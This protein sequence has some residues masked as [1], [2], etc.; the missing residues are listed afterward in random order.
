MAAH[1]RRLASEPGITARSVA[2]VDDGRTVFTRTMG[3]ADRKARRPVDDRTVFRPA[4]L[5][6]PVFAYLV[7]R[8]ADE[9]VLDLDTPVVRDLPKPLPAYPAY[10]SLRDDTRYVRRA[11]RGRSGQRPR[12]ADPGVAAYRERGGVAP[13]HGGRLRPVPRRRAD[14]R[15]P[16]CEEPRR[17]AG[18]GGGPAIVMLSVS[19]RPDSF[20]APLVEAAIGSAYSPLAW[21]ESGHIVPSEPS[22]RVLRWGLAGLAL[23]LP[24]LVLWR[25]G[26]VGTRVS[27]R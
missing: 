3:V 23:I 10:A 1:L 27:W 11:V 21:L 17:D 15:R 6:K 25:A 19:A 13:H 16:G 24:V 26:R 14:G 22:G 4:S 12:R 5:G 20:P 9:G 8:L 2:V 18:P 7:M